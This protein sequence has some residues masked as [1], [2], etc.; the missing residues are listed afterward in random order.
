MDRQ[1]KQNWTTYESHFQWKWAERWEFNVYKNI[2]VIS[3]K[4]ILNDI[5]NSTYEIS[6]IT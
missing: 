3:D 4:K 5:K 6:I 1:K 2:V